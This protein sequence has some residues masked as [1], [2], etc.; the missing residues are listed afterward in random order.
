MLS[1]KF[2]VS[3]VVTLAVLA[4]G[5]VLWAQNPTRTI[6]TVPD[7]HCMGCAKKMATRLYQVPGVAKVEANVPAT[8]LTLTPQAQRAPSPR[9]LWEAI[10]GA[11]YRPSKLEGPGG[12]YTSKPKT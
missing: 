11:G 1:Q 12:T 9:A 10:E 6:I 8:T 7:M 2:T 5:N 4:G 3:V